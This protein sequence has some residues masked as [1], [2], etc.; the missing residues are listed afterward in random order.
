VILEVLAGVRTTGDAAKARAV[1][2]W[3][4]LPP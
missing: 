4:A 2:L 3:Q 1:S